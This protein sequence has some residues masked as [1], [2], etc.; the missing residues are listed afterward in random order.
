LPDYPQWRPDF[1][2]GGF[3]DWTPH[4]TQSAF[5]LRRE[6]KATE[7]SD[8]RESQKADWNS[9]AR[10][11]PAAHLS[12]QE[13]AAL[14]GTDGEPLSGVGPSSSGPG[15]GAELSLPAHLPAHRLLSSR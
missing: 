9:C 14:E 3:Y 11:G 10:P 1:C 6:E 15:G 12:L 4:H 5:P 7:Y 2:C 13:T 8:N